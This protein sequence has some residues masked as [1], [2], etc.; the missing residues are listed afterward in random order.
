MVAFLISFFASMGGVSGAFLILP[1]QVSVLGFNTPAVSATNQLYNIVAIPSGVYRYI[2]EGR[3]VWPLAWAIIIGT[4]PGVVVGALIR[5]HYF[6]DPRTFKMFVG[7]VLLY[8]GGRMLREVLKKR[9]RGDNHL[10]AEE[11]FQKIVREYHQSQRANGG[12]AKKDREIPKVITGRYRF[13]R[14][15]YEF[16]GQTFDI[17]AV[18][19]MALS[20]IV[21]IVGGI[22]GIGGGAILVPIFVSFFRLPVYTIG[23]AALMGTFVTSIT[24][25]L[26]FQI[27]AIFYTGIAVAPDWALGVLFGVGGFVGM[28]CGARLQKFMPAR[29]IKWILVAFLLFI[30][31]KYCLEFFR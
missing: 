10:S 24:A 14:V 21:G 22:Y 7:V 27:M 23:G 29:V 15:T 20:L 1:F 28:Y 11:K 26:V 17:N 25:V 5:V 9:S 16:Y 19:I 30:A 3:M 13:T 31:A 8:I 12:I 18:G 2:K 6:P 4:A